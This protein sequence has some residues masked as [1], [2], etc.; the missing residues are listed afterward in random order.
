MAVYRSKKKKENGSEFAPKRKEVT[1]KTPISEDSMERLVRLMNDS[2]TLV[3]FANTE[4]AIRSLR[5][6]TQ[7]LIAEHAC[8]IIKREGMALGDIIKEFALVLPEVAHCITLALLNDRDRIFYNYET[9]E[10]SPEY[11]QVYDTLLWGNC[12]A[13]EWAMFLAEIF[14]LIDT[15]FF[16]QSTNVIETI[17]Q[18]TLARK[19]TKTE[20]E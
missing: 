1:P 5:M 2:P 18:T 12:D 19:T 16:F 7:W 14:N 20:R 10:L 13:K 4:W 17:R 9:K 8:Q 6:G 11:N 15:S 3:K